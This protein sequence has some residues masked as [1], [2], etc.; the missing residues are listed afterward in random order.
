MSTTHS[1][2]D[3][4]ITN[5]HIEKYGLSVV[6]IEATEYL[7]SFGYSIGLWERYHH[8]EI[9]CFGFSI[10]N[11]QILINDAANIVK[12]GEQIITNKTYG[13]LKGCDTVFIN[14]HPSYI[15]D[16]FG[17]AIRHYH[18][19]NFTALQF[20]WPDRKNKFPWQS[21]FEE[22]FIYKQ[23]L[24][25]RNTD[26]KFREARNLGVFTTK[27]WLLQKKPIVR[28][29]HDSDGDWQFLTGDQVLADAS[30]VALEQMTIRDATLNEVFNLDYGEY[31]E[32]GFIGDIWVRGISDVE[33]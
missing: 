14:V 8:P 10:K 21:G 33:E 32:R 16:Y 28:V 26:F 15:P 30:I 18:H 31:A 11:L 27:Q 2:N 9:I 13:L 12:Q 22:E 7:P 29:V 23:P 20:V 5:E 17:A 3:N 25:D 24:L 1:H 6:L 19:Q 4:N